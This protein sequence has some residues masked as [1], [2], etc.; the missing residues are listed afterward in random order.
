[1]GQGA[2]RRAR[3]RT[4]RRSQAARRETPRPPRRGRRASTPRYER[5]KRSA[6]LLDFDDLIGACTEALETDPEFAAV[7]RWRFRHLFVDE[8]QDVTRAQLDLLRAWLG[9]GTDLCV[10]GDPDQAIYAFAGADAGLLTRFPDEFAGRGGRPAR[11]ELP[12]DARDR[13]RPRGRCC[14]EHERADG[15]RRRGRGSA[16]DRSPRTPNDD[17][18]ARGVADALYRAHGP[19]RPWSSMAVL[20]RVNAQSAPFEEALRPRRGPLPGARARPRSST[21]PR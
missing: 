3:A 21:G 16:P 20:Y 9:D 17:A 6:G 4:P 8:F 7:Q 1:M 19:M 15:A 18:E 12:L 11:R 13:A 5:E 2:P 14:R 10:V